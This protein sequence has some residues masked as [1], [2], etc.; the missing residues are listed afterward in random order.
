[1]SVGERIKAARLHSGLSVDEIA[2]KINKDRSTVY[3]YESQE[4][5]EL[6]ITILEPLA[7]ALG[8]T[9]SYLMG[10]DDKLKA[11]TIT[12]DFVVF[13]V[14]GELAAGYEHIALENWGGETIEIPSRY[15]RGHK[16]DDFIVLK[17]KGD[18]MY[19][20][21]QNDDVVLVLKQDTMN[22]SGEIGAVIYEDENA[23]LKKIEYVEGEDWMKLVPLNPEYMP[24]TIT[25]E[26]LEHCR[27]IGIPKL[28][29][30]EIS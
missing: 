24:K 22:H 30:R 13:P 2:K 25:G 29:I 7:N 14:I 17:V 6:P 3:R 4:I 5:E 19:P 18:S 16:K 10:W 23:T 8:T 28:L 27:V 1:M 15:L 21:Y 9:V 12:D 11:P 26:N 20:M